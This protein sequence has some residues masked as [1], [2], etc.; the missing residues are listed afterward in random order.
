MADL[1][2]DVVPGPAAISALTERATTFLTEAGVD[3]GAAG[4]C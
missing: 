3:P 2:L 4:L 1:R